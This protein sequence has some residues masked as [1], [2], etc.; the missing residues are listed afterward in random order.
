[1]MVNPRAPRVYSTTTPMKLPLTLAALLFTSLCAIRAAE[2]LTVLPPTIDGVAPTA[3][4][5]AQLKKLAFAALDRRDAEYEKIKTRDDVAAWQQRERAAF[6]AAI[7]GLPERTPLNPR[8][9]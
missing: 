2:D 5:E 3:L 8:V 7:G 1:M 6:L 9:T 4:L